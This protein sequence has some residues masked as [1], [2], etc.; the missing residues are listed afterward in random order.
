MVQ[1]AQQVTHINLPIGE[2]QKPSYM[3]GL[4]DIG[5]GLNLVNVEYHQSVAGR[6][7]HLVLTFVYLKG[8]YDVDP[9]NISR[10]GI[11]K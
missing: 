7:P 6:H 2:V 11:G 8:L 4:A 1:I 5:S 10:V 3:S 9:I